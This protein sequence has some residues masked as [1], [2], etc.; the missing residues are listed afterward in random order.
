[1]KFPRTANALLLNSC[2]K[3]QEK[4]LRKTN[5][6]VVAGIADSVGI[7]DNHWPDKIIHFPAFFLLAGVTVLHP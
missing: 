7:I 1:M 2:H 5:G 3:K 6:F 4:Y